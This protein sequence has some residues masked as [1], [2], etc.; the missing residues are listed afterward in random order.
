MARGTPALVGWLAVA[1][2]ALILLFSGVTL[3]LGLRESDEPGF[4]RQLF[5]SAL[6]ALDP[7]T[8]AGDVGDWQFLLTMLLLTLGGLFIV[9]AL[10]GVIATGLDRKIEELRKGRSFV[11]EREHTLILGWSD[12]I[13][14]ILGE[15]A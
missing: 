11:I 9:S 5:D 6:H 12:T 7:G 3:L 2:F 15:L 13:F 14:T 4:I 8:V 10:I 1:T